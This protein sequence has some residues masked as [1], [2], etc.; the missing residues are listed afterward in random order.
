M[1]AQP[2]YA[3]YEKWLE[4]KWSELAFFHKVYTIE[5]PFSK[6]WT[7]RFTLCKLVLRSAFV[8]LTTLIALMLPFFNAVVGFLGAIAFWP[9]TVYYPVTCYMA[10]AKIKRG[11][12]KWVVLQCLSM[13]ALLVSLL[14]A[15]GS[16]ADIAQRLK[17]VTLFKAEF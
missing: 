12:V 10:Q 8:V 14:A 15:I 4:K 11:E 3:K 2:I 6:G 7:F 5:L 13:G 16:V 17:H 1:Y 9:L